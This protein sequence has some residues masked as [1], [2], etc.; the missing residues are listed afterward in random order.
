MNDSHAT[1]FTKGSSASRPAS[2]DGL[3]IIIESPQ[4]TQSHKKRPRLVTSCD[5]CRLKKIKCL[6]PSPETQCEACTIAKIPCRFRDRERY[7]AERSR[8]ITD[9]NARP[10]NR[11]DR[12]ASGDNSSR[13]Y[14]AQYPQLPSSSSRAPQYSPTP[15]DKGHYPQFYSSSEYTGPQRNTSGDEQAHLSNPSV[16]ETYPRPSSHAPYYDDSQLFDPVHSQFPQIGRMNEFMTQ[17]VGLSESFRFLS[18]EDLVDRFNRRTLSPLMANCIATWG[19]FALAMSGKCSYSI[20]EA[21]CGNATDLLVACIEQPTLE[22]LHCMMLLAWYEAR[23]GRLDRFRQLC[24]ISIKTARGLGLVDQ[25]LQ[26][27]SY[28]PYHELAVNL[29]RLQNYADSLASPRASGP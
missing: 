17:F 23:N 12:P 15:A 13:E 19:S 20:A 16:P 26:L 1:T 29:N 14:P 18:H 7:F 25:S 3:Q 22:V 24:D 8:A 9:L 2:M 6:Q 21:Y 28:N 11:L 5:N 27:S 10:P 4:D